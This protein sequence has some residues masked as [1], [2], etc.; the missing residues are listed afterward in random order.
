MICS[1][2]SKGIETLKTCG[3]LI[4]VDR[5]TRTVFGSADERAVRA[6]LFGISYVLEVVNKTE[7]K[8]VWIDMKLTFYIS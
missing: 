4:R 3:S 8:H 1:A 7:W 6:S 5:E 2:P